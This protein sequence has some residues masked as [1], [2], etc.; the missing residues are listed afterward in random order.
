MDKSFKL[1]NGVIIPKLCFGS[2]I[3]HTYRHDNES[4]LGYAK[5]KLKTRI[6]NRKQY[7][8]DSN[9]NRNISICMEN[10]LNMFDTSKAYGDGE[11]ELGR[12][13]KKYRRDDYF[14]VTKA[15]NYDQYNGDIRKA[16]EDS[17]KAL[18][19]KYVDLY[20]LHWPVSDIWISS[21]LQLEKLYKEGLCR[22]IGV[23]NCNI[24]H[25]EELKKYAQVIPMV[26][27]FEC[28]PLF[29]QN[30]LRDYCKANK[31][32]VMAY[33][34]TARMDER[35]YKTKLVPIAKKYGK[36]IPQVMLKWHQQIGN[37]PIFNSGDP[38]H[39][40]CNSMI[41]DF[42]LMQDEL[43]KITAINI[44]SRLRYDP[45]NCDFRQL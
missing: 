10:G 34:A 9:F 12:A 33:T 38:E 4:F 35:I 1:S 32:Q 15:S 28:H 18:D 23:C 2:G 41:D 3:V 44:N 31:I 40:K 45:D 25:I 14:I 24:H 27:E 13:L 43:Q 29:T 21:W 5:Y 19:M 42:S 8:L 6:K 36:S 30:E 39:V 22:A 37:I 11:H 7:R 16:L 26:N 20:L 17:L